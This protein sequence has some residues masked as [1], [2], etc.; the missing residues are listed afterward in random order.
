M[1][2]TFLKARGLDV[3]KSLVEA[4]KLGLARELE[5]KAA[6]K[7]VRLLLPTDHVVGDLSRPEVEPQTV[8]ADATPADLAGYDIGPE[9]L[10]AY[11]EA[12]ST[13]KTVIWNGP[14]GIFEN[15]LYAKGTMGV[16]EAVAACE[17]TTIIGGGDSVAAI[18]QAGLAEKVSHV[19]TGGGASLE[20]LAGLIL[21][22]VAAL[23]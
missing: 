21:P 2:Y 19:S 4:D 10:A 9:T 11:R 12:L 3:G 17:G 6:E 1:A 23:E 18:N 5:A 15:P 16:A 20:F 14:M 22:G 7:G 13:A 8:A